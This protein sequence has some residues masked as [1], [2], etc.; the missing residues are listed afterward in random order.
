MKANQIEIPLNF[1]NY[2]LLKDKSF[3]LSGSYIYFIEGSNDKGKT[4]F[5]DALSSLMLAKNTVDEPVTRGELD[6]HIEGT[7]PGADERSYLVKFSFSKDKE[8]FV[9]VDPNGIIIDKV[10][11]I[12]SIFKYTHFTASEFL[13]LSLSSEGRKKQ[14]EIILNILP[15]DSKNDYLKSK[16]LEK[17]SYD[18]RTKIKNHLETA[19][20]I[21]EQGSLND[22]DKELLK[23]EIE[24]NDSLLL[25]KEQLSKAW[26]LE[27][28]KSNIDSFIQLLSSTVLPASAKVKEILKDKFDGIEDTFIGIIRELEE[29][30]ENIKFDLTIEE[31]KQRIANGETLRDKI[32]AIKQ[33]DESYQLA[34][35]NKKTYET[36]YLSLSDKI[37]K[38]RKK[39]K[40]I[41]V[42]AKLPISNL[43]INDDGITIDG[44]SFNESQICK[45]SA[46]KVVAG[47]MCNINK[48][49][50]LLM[51]SADELDFDSLNSLL[52]IAEK[53]N[54]VMIFDS[55]VK[56]NQEIQVVGY[57][58]TNKTE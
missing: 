18:E 13:N 35:K 21:A 30:K 1:H 52:E 37:D 25:R 8:K 29:E 4:S 47:L 55:V 6:G 7:I 56:T 36:E 2:K 12:R 27:Q 22:A 54:K 49:P 38:E 28:Q 20:R 19:K 50:I 31:I 40:D 9:V 43:E 39:Q 15:D 53:H 48:S 32:V 11:D 51:G 42:N 58:K 33:K 14:R 41:I 46:I 44:F 45:S 34:V 17:S 23:K 26:L 3:N 24:I 10:T 16:S 57:D 5:L